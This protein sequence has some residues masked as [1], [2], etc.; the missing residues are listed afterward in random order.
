MKSLGPE[1][2][3]RLMEEFRCYLE[4]GNGETDE[5]EEMEELVDLRTLLGEMAAL[6]NEV[7]LESRQFKNTLEE[8]RGFG[9]AL[10]EHN[11]R[12]VRD[13]ERLREQAA[14]AQ[15][16]VE[17]PLLL[18]LLDLRDRLQAGADAPA[19]AR[20]SAFARFLAP[21][22]TR[23]ARSLMEGTQLT[24]QR[25]DD[26]LVSHQVRAIETLGQALDP[27]T[28][29]A[30]ATESVSSAPGGTVLREA[31]RGFTH[32]GELLRA[33]EVIVNKRTS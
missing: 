28:M 9:E 15:R 21:G 30:V 10:R 1:E 20:T 27:H 5:D 26:L 22:P 11:E 33:A 29:C 32:A 23:L 16:Q 24:L 19:A 3:E 18:G 8:L 14:E 6:K 4:Q 17:R 25:L 2:K 7:R 31:R 12:L 13:L